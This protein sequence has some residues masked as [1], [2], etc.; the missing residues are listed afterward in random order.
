LRH[1]RQLIAWL[2]AASGAGGAAARG[3]P[4]MAM[5]GGAPIVPVQPARDRTASANADDLI[6]FRLG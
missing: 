3:A 6:I 4:D 2:C 1:L 5:L